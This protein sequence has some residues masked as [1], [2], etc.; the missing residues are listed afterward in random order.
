MQALMAFILVLPSTAQTSNSTNEKEVLVLLN[1]SMGDIKVA[2]YNQTPKHRDNFVKLVNDGFYNGVL[3]HRVISEF[4]IQGGDPESKNPS[5]GQVLG[6]GGPGYT[7]PAEFVDSLYHIKG[8]L[9]A[10]RQGDQVNPER[11]SSGSQFYIVQGKKF[12]EDQLKNFEEQIN[13]QRKNQILAMLLDNPQNARL[14]RQLEG[15][16][17]IGNQSEL[18]FMLQQLG[19][20]LE[21]ELN[22]QGKFFY[23]P[24]AIKIYTEQG[25]TP[26]LDGA[27][28]VFGQVVEGLDVVDKIA[29]V[30]TGQGNRPTE[31][32]KV[33][34]A[35]VVKK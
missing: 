10:A 25:G 18:N 11:A 19:P 16:V 1:T 20:T 8:A 7:T 2:L 17:K 5:P 13:N 6:N 9:A 31:D 21:E 26:H 34:K 28:T 24:E 15:Y 32:V 27:Y 3:F 14:K 29:G 4:M 35:K 30:A 12:T 33:I 22:K 23:T